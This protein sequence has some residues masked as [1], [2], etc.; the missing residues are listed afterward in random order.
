MLFMIRHG[1]QSMGPSPG[2][3]PEGYAI[4]DTSK[5]SKYV[6]Y[7]ITDDDM[8]ARVAAIKK[9]NFQTLYSYIP[10]YFTGTDN[11]NHEFIRPNYGSLVVEDVPHQWSLIE[12]CFA[13]YSGYDSGEGYIILRQ[14]NS[15]SLEIH[16][17]D[18]YGC[19]YTDLGYEDS[20]QE[21]RSDT[22]NV[23]K[24]HYDGTR[25][26][27]TLFLVFIEDKVR[28]Y[29][30]VNDGFDEYDSYIRTINNNVAYITESTIY[31]SELEDAKTIASLDLYPYIGDEIMYGGTTNHNTNARVYSVRKFSGMGN[32][33]DNSLDA[34]FAQHFEVDKKLFLQDAIANH[35]GN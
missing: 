24:A 22:V 3:E 30:G 18:N 11:V 23:I 8:D 6:A 13:P 19:I 31:T 10:Q 34:T 35:G 17:N 33:A 9:N 32:L 20:N 29:L 25:I 7:D 16:H 1:R 2:P 27:C 15:I 5:L 28:T 21:H 14:N 26:L 4:Y 12:I